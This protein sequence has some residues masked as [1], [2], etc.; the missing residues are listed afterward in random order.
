MAN[1]DTP[2]EGARPP[3]TEEVGA[4]APDPA[5]REA[6][7]N[8]LLYS[9]VWCLVRPTPACKFGKPTANGLLCQ[10]PRRERIVARTVARRNASAR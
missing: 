3:W 4:G 10:H 2:N 6:R 5:K 8:D 9:V 1:A 7:S